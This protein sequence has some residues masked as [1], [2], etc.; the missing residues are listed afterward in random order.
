MTGG[1]ENRKCKIHSC[2]SNHEAKRN[3][4]HS[5]GGSMIEWTQ[6]LNGNEIDEREGEG[7]SHICPLLFRV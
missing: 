6:G 3:K 7:M 4:G 5:E 2:V 1:R